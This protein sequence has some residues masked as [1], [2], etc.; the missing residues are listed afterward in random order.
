MASLTCVRPGPLAQK[1][2]QMKAFR[3]SN[4]IFP[5]LPVT[6]TQGV[7]VNHSKPVEKPNQQHQE[8]SELSMMD[9][10]S[11]SG[12]FTS[13]STRPNILEARPGN[14]PML[15]KFSQKL[16]Q[17]LEDHLVY[18]VSILPRQLSSR[19]N[20]GPRSQ[21][22]RPCDLTTRSTPS[23]ATST[24]SFPNSNNDDK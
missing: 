10:S 14:F 3:R 13:H 7:P 23:R 1:N 11:N 21:H 12:N 8:S 17:Q 18:T 22:G 6:T 2:T 4:T 15:C 5:I 20:L 19:P 16:Q 24:N 9:V